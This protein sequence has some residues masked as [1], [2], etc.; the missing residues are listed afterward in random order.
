MIS[1]QLLAAINDKRRYWSLE[2]EVLDRI[3]CRTHF[4]RDYETTQTHTGQS[5][6]ILLENRFK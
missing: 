3:L 1:K 4:G 2:K 5:D 6:I